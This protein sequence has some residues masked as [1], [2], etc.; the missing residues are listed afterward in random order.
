MKDR[1]DAGKYENKTEGGVLILVK[2]NT[3]VD[4]LAP[5]Y[6]VP[7]RVLK[8][9]GVNVKIERVVEDTAV[10]HLNRCKSYTQN[11]TVNTESDDSKY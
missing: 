1:Y 4:C 11:D 5:H 6:K 10:V 3:R 2:D 8:R 9:F 7:S